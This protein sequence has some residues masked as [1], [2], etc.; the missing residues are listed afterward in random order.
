MLLLINF[1]YLG[2]V[3]AALAALLLPATF[4]SGLRFIIFGFAASENAA[5]SAALFLAHFLFFFCCL[6]FCRKQN[7]A[8]TGNNGNAAS[9]PLLLK[10][11]FHVVPYPA[12]ASS[13]CSF[14]PSIA[15]P[16]PTPFL[17]SPNSLTAVCCGHH[18]TYPASKKVGQKGLAC[19][20]CILRFSAIKFNISTFCLKLVLVAFYI[21]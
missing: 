1:V 21:F 16:C 5:A 17:N 8:Q 19:L 7:C 4:L 14:P 15:R 13:F 10:H 18:L 2:K 6:F 20:I 3:F 9:F 11:T 12:A